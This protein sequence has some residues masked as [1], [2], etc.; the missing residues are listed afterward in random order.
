MRCARQCVD[1][2][3]RLAERIPTRDVES[4]AGWCRHRN[5]VNHLDLVTS[6]LIRPHLDAS[7]GTAIR[8]KDFGRS[9]IVDPFRAV[10]RRRGLAR[11]DTCRWDHNHTPF[12]RVMAVTSAPVGR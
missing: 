3:D 12:A 4:G 2:S 7:W 6:D 1:R 5:S 10:Y 11:D 8:P 9:V